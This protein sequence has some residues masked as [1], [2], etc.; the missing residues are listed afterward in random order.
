MQKCR[1]FRRYGGEADRKR[2]TPIRGF[3]HGL[4]VDVPGDL[5]S[6]GVYEAHLDIAEQGNGM[7]RAYFSSF[8]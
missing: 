2:G 1:N 6:S 8:L 4:P 5:F 7:F 3:S